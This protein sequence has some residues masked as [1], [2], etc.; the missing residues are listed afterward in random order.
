MKTIIKKLFQRYG[1]FNIFKYFQAELYVFRGIRYEDI[2]LY[3]Y[4]KGDLIF[5]HIPKAAGMSIVKAIY[6]RDFS[7]H[8]S[9]SDYIKQDAE[10]F[11]DSFSFSVCRNPYTRF[12]S[13]YTY[14][15]RGGMNPMDKVW[16]RKY[17]SKYKDINDFAVNGL[18]V[19]I[20]E[21]AEHFKSQ[22]SFIVNEDGKIA[23][24]RVFK[25]EEIDLMVEELGCRGVFI[26]LPK[27]NS[28]PEDTGRS[29]NLSTK[30]ISMINECYHD[31]FELLGYRK[32]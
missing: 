13:A 16:Y 28:S 5:I 2:D 18:R 6:Q 9:A 29:C 32:K 24:D 31:D 27:I 22:I 7:H 12:I 26:D 30:A 19:A 14:L 23:C 20:S 8:A 11:G 10:L 3:S 4:I 21:G 15:S 17:I 25:V 1:L